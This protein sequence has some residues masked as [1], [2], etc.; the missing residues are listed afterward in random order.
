MICVCKSCQRQSWVRGAW[1]GR[2]KV[3]DSDRSLAPPRVG[4]YGNLALGQKGDGRGS[5]WVGVLATGLLTQ[6]EGSL[7]GAPLL[8]VRGSHV[9][10]LTP[11]LAWRVKSN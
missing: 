9:K 7:C 10:P 3:T 4:P 1:W 8:G 5:L 6:V 11:R 2:E